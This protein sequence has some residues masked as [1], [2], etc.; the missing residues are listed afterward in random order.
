M[1]E[2]FPE[3]E[4]REPLTECLECG[5]SLYKGDVAADVPNGYICRGCWQKVALE[6]AKRDEMKEFIQE[7]DDKKEFGKWYF[8]PQIVV[9]EDVSNDN[10]E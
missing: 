4:E 10:H 2:Y 9:L 7:Y 1:L 8:E 6:N 3:P 5:E